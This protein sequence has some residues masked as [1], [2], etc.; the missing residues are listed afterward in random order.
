MAALTNCSTCQDLVG[1]LHVV[2]DLLQSVSKCSPAKSERALVGNEFQS[3]ALPGALPV[4]Q[5]NPQVIVV[6]QGLTPSWYCRGLQ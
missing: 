6:F 3:E 2:L 1:F 5:N 4:G